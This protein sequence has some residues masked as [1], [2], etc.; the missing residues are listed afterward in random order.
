MTD[1]KSH[2]ETPRWQSWISFLGNLWNV[3]PCD[4]HL[5]LF[6]YLFFL[7]VHPP[8]AFQ[9]CT[10]GNWQHLLQQDQH[11]GFSLVG[12]FY[13]FMF[14]NTNSF[15]N[16][17]LSQTVCKFDMQHCIICCFWYIKFKF[18]ITEHLPFSE[19]RRI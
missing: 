16:F 7:Q 1:T 8:F 3:V 17:I 15:L 11:F 19:P 10:E 4:W 12:R 6:I 14:M 9:S 5:W 18:F 13:T 2:C